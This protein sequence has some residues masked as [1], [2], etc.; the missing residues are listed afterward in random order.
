MT[1]DSSLARARVN[2]YLC[3]QRGLG[4]VVL[5]AGGFKATSLPPTEADTLLVRKKGDWVWGWHRVDVT[6]SK[7]LKSKNRT[8]EKHLKI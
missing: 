6:P 8:N 5:K 1:S 4:N 7:D 2:G 3:L